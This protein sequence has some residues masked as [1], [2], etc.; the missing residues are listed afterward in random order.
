MKCPKCGKE[1]ANDSQFCEFCG[2][3][4]IHSK[5]NT[6]IVWVILSVICGAVVF[7][8][9]ILHEHNNQSKIADDSHKEA[10]Y[11]DSLVA[12]GYVDLGLPSGT[13]WKNRNEKG[14]FTLALA[15]SRFS[16]E[17]LKQGNCQYSYEGF[18]TFDEAVS[19]YNRNLPTKEQYEE[20]ISVCKWLWKG[21]GYEV[22]G[23]N[24]AKIFF[25]AAGHRPTCCLFDSGV[26]SYGSYWSSSWSNN[27]PWSLMFSSEYKQQMSDLY[28]EYNGH[29]VRLVHK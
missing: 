9:I 23:P 28:D 24:G 26:D 17:E 12:V 2:T 22:Y 20:L 14:I 8:G 29:S 3:Q 25:P 6:K 5:K 1:I 16:E 7:G 4:V 21:N 15:K 18:F 11:R 27:S 10:A 19:K 13:L